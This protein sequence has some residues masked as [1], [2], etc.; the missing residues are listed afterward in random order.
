MVIGICIQTK[1]LKI[2]KFS[3][4]KHEKINEWEDFIPAK[5]M[6]VI[7]GGLTFLKN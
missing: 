5:K 3:R 2:L 1:M 6:E 7:I 4:C